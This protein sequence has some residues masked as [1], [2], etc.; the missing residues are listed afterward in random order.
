MAEP[1]VPE[2]EAIPPAMRLQAC[3]TAAWTTQAVYV[4]AELGLADLLAARPCTGAEL[5]AATNSHEASL[6]RL[7]RALSA[8]GFCHSA[9]G[10]A[11]ELASM[12]TLLRSDSA[13]S[14]RAWALWWGRSLWPA[15]GHLLHSVRTGA[16]ARELVSGTHG[17]SHLEN[18][19]GAAAIFYQATVE[20]SR[21]SAPAILAAYDFSG[22]RRIV[23]VGGGYGELLSWILRSNPSATGVLFELPQAVAGA[24]RHLEHLGLAGRCETVEGDFFKQIP[25]GADA[26]LLTSVL[27]NW[28]DEPAGRILMECRR[29]M[30]ENAR[31]ILVEQ[32][33]TRE[34]EVLERPLALSDLTMLVAHG[35]GERTRK[36]LEAL[37]HTAGLA[38][39]RVI[40]AGGSLHIIEAVPVPHPARTP[41]QH[42]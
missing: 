30:G 19:P 27:H 5:A 25:P 6:R 29:A 37:L 22:F 7:L 18:D 14:L 33:L 13:D 12:G 26:Y 32:V 39:T 24:R 34:S 11:F 9:P 41:A 42:L 20:L 10:D 2:M 15:W 23:D 1:G 28:N 38:V 36:E 8:I 4:A 35:A 16:S 17:F 40:P 21:A 3:L 31:L